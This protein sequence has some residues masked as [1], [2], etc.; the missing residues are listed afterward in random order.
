MTISLNQVQFWS[1]KHSFGDSG[2]RKTYL[3]FLI[4]RIIF[5]IF[6][7]D[8]QHLF[9]RGMV[10]N[11][12]ANYQVLILVAADLFFIIALSVSKFIILLGK[13][14]FPIFNFSTVSILFLAQFWWESGNQMISGISH[15]PLINPFFIFYFI[16]LFLYGWQHKL[17]VLLFYITGVVAV[18][19]LIILYLNPAELKE[20][21]ISY[22]VFVAVFVLVA[23]TLS[24][25]ISERLIH[26]NDVKRAHLK[27]KA[28]SKRLATALLTHEE[29]TISRERNRL[30]RELHDTLSHSLSALSVQLEASKSVWEHDPDRAKLLLVQAQETVRT[31]MKDAR[32]SLSDLRAKP[33]E[34]L[35]LLLACRELMVQGLF[36][37]GIEGE[38]FIPDSSIPTGLEPYQEH[39]IYRVFQEA[40]ENMVR[41]SQADNAELLISLDEGFLLRLEDG[42]VGFS[43]E[44]PGL[45]Q[46]GHHFG[47]QGMEERALIVGGSLSIL[48]Q[49]GK[50]TVLTLEIQNK[51]EEDA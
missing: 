12:L 43:M 19:V 20:V 18:N 40:V 11:P 23:W 44:E 5:W 47:I 6:L 28:I 33:L 38:V 51:E 16:T 17:S 34:D 29:L 46:N 1:M 31:G 4:V 24:M 42:G 45:Q 8:F 26:E 10:G 39:G 14:F 7:N 15:N 50:G 3:F 49:P 25:M 37:L 48:S 9:L 27:E 36:R 2:I 21:F 22:V 35:G 41:H 13:R 32:S 30:A